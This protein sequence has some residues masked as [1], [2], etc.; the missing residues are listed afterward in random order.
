MRS[1][2]L[3]LDKVYEL[4]YD[5]T[6]VWILDHITTGGFDALFYR[7]PDLD[8]ARVLFWAG[9]QHNHPCEIEESEKILNINIENNKIKLLEIYAAIFEA[10]DLAEWTYNV[11]DIV[12]GKQPVNL[13]KKREIST[14]DKIREI[15]QITLTFLDI[16]P[17]TLWKLTPQEIDQMI[18]G[19]SFRQQIEDMRHNIKIFGSEN[20][21]ANSSN[22]S[23]IMNTVVAAHGGTVK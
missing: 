15:E 3:L 6:S 16:D 23:N 21:T 18:K 9:I 17:I 14:S 13:D 7:K 1:I 2:P 5:L 22:V 4:R 20:K 10:L 12:S 11:Y 19:S 8:T